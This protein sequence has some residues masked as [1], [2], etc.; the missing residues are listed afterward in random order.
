MDAIWC[1]YKWQIKYVRTIVFPTHRLLPQRTIAHMT[2]NVKDD[3]LPRFLINDRLLKAGVINA[4][5]Q[6]INPKK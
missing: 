4:A 3:D 2:Y 6:L 5:V 1:R